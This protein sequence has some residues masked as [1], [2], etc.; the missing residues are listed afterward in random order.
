MGNFIPTGSSG[1]GRTLI[2]YFDA[3]QTALRVPAIWDDA[4]GSREFTSYLVDEQRISLDVPGWTQLHGITGISNDGRTI[5]G[6]G[7]NTSGE[8]QFVVRVGEFEECDL[9]ADLSCDAADIDAFA[10]IKRSHLNRSSF[11]LNLRRCDY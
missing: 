8:T 4:N 1:N 7:Y 11:D 3:E 2:G 5:I 6:Y 9:N 10:E